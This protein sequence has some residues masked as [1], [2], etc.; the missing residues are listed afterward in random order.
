MTPEQELN[1]AAEMLRQINPFD[2]LTFEHV[3]D[4]G[5]GMSAHIIWPA[6]SPPIDLRRRRR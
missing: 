5:N 3:R 4:I 1:A 2:V 6:S